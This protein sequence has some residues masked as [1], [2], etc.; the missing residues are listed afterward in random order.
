M[1]DLDFWPPHSHITIFTHTHTHRHEC[2][3]MHR[4]TCIHAHIHKCVYMH[5]WTCT[6]THAHEHT[7]THEHMH[8]YSHTYMHTQTHASTRKPSALHFHADQP[9]SAHSRVKRQLTLHHLSPF[10]AS[11]SA[12]KN[13][14]AP[15]STS[16]RSFLCMLALEGF[17]GWYLHQED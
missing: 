12:D 4:W 7:H 9:V 14:L 10:I 13:I 17:R 16:P 1:L 15:I 3:H 8:T 5:T 11:Q 6:H 2:V